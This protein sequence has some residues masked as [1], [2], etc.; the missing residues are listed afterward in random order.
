METRATRKPLKLPSTTKGLFR[1]AVR[2]AKADMIARAQAAAKEQDP[3][4]RIAKRPIVS[5]EELP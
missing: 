2:R 3:F 1:A 4:F 5:D